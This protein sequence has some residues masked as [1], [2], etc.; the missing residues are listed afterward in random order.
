MKEKVYC[1]HDNY[2][3]IILSGVADCEGYPCYFDF[4]PG[5]GI[6]KDGTQ[7]FL[8]TLLDTETF[9]RELENWNYWLFWQ[10][11][12]GVPHPQTYIKLRQT[13]TIDSI[14]ADKNWADTG[15]WARLEN[16]YQNQLLVE[17][18]L[19]DH[20]PQI[21]ATAIFYGDRDGTDTEVEWT[22][23]NRLTENNGS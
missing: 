3:S 6:A 8:L 5:D 9:T 4:L 23:V 16:Y 19:K 18:Y 11:Q 22:I 1:S 13:S 14:T 2:D 21:K 15:N 10:T 12:K 17:A 20:P 7:I